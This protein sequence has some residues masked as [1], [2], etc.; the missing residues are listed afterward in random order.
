MS[1]ASAWEHASTIVST[2]SIPRTSPFRHL[3]M[4]DG[5]ND[6]IGTKLALGVITV[7]RSVP[8]LRDARAAIIGAPTYGPPPTITNLPF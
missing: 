3:T 2:S 5:E 4:Y 1:N 6:A 8:A 7:T